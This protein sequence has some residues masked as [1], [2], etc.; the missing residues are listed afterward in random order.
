MTV[1]DDS[2]GMLALTV[3]DDHQHRR[4]GCSPKLFFFYLWKWILTFYHATPIL[5]CLW[6][7]MM[8]LLAGHFYNVI[9]S[10]LDALAIYI[11][12][13]GL[14]YL[15]HLGYIFFCF[16]MTC[17]ILILL[18]SC[19]TTRLALETLFQRRFC[20]QP[21]PFLSRF[22]IG[23]LFSIAYLAFLIQIILVIATTTIYI[24]SCVN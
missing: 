11:T 1:A 8:L 17:D 9:S 13:P 10:L 19:F 3:Q 21:L 7:F 23:L 16:L 5:T 14:K 22:L 2:A 4:P 18:A 12:S 15:H 6:T 24:V 20:H